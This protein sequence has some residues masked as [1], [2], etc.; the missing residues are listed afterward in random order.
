MSDNDLLILP[1]D[2][3]LLDLSLILLILLD[4]LLSHFLLSIKL[5]LELSLLFLVLSFECFLSSL[6]CLLLDGDELVWL[7]VYLGLQSLLVGLL[8]GLFE[9][10]FHSLKL[11]SL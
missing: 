7:R 4:L 10:H 5:F 8:G 2:L 9:G 11:L 3:S 1:L 6:L